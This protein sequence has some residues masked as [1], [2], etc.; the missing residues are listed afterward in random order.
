M[1]KIFSFL[2]VLSLLCL[3]PVFAYADVLTPGQAFAEELRRNG[4]L[5][6]AAAVLVVAFILWRVLRKKK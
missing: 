1:K 6:I 4:L 3:C 2:T 5:L